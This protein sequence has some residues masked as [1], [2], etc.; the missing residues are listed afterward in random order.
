M[1]DDNDELMDC[2]TRMKGDGQPFALATVVRTEN[3][4][5]AKAGAKAVV[6]ADGSLVGWIGGGCA[7]RVVKQAAAGALAD[8]ETRLVRVE[9]EDVLEED[10]IPEGMEGHVSH[11]PSRGTADI[12]V[13]PI[14]PRPRLVIAGASPVARALADLAGRMGYV[15]TVA[16]LAEDQALF[17]AA[18]ERIENF[19]IAGLPRIDKSFVV[20]ATQGKRDR[21]ALRHA[22]E[23]EAPFV[24]F[25]GSRR[26]ADA[27]KSALLEA[28]VD[29]ARVDA[30]KAPAGLDLGAVM[31]DEIALSVLAEVVQARRRKGVAVED[32]TLANA[33]QALTMGPGAETRD[34][35]VSAVLLAAGQSR[36][37]GD[38]N[39]LL[40]DIDGKPMVR[41]T[42]EALLASSVGEVIAV[43][44]FDHEAVVSALDGLAIK[45]VFNPDFE[46][47]QMSSVR[48]GL[49][50]LENEAGGV[51]ICLGDQPMLTARD[52]ELMIGTWGDL[53]PGKIAVPA[54]LG[55]RGNP[56][57]LPLASRR[58]ILERD[59]K[60]GCRNLIEDNPD[61]VTVIEVE[62][63]GFVRD[64]DTP[65]DYNTTLQPRL[66][67]FPRCC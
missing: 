1:I 44:G 27:L 45:C 19:S 39:K 56:I 3:L 62:S 31:P 34:G 15:V 52:Y 58:D 5:A 55:V 29:A 7:Q 60:F 20:I 42:A 33:P 11:C 24:A 48:A 54:H 35:T 4:T 17:E 9:P 61:L 16:A 50:G 18:D 66:D 22:L 53:E 64:I 12:F 65:D 46:T 47:G 41:R 6:R 28:G 38:T 10:E 30:L 2:M 32:Q 8:G 23:S 67:A 14:L 37:M 63:A 25:V 40:L 26:K 36:R 51:M 49:A 57:V 43:V 13:E 21:E 59:I